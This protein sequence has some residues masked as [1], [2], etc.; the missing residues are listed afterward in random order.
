MGGSNRETRDKMNT[1]GSWEGYSLTEK[2]YLKI[3][4]Y[5]HTDT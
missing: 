2:Y 3:Y 1:Y 4:C 5:I